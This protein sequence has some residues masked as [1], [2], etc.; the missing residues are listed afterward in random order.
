MIA[1]LSAMFSFSCITVLWILTMERGT[2]LDSEELAVV[3]ALH[4]DRMSQREI[5]KRVNRS[6]TAIRSVE[7]D[8]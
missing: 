2:Q 6:K 5:A 3:R 8:C 4:A 7:M 1:R